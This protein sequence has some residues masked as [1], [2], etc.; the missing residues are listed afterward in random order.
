MIKSSTI[1][2]L[3]VWCFKALTERTKKKIVLTISIA[4]AIKLR[5][6][7]SLYE[8]QPASRTFANVPNQPTTSGKDRLQ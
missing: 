1:G 8:S 7:V 2:T 3:I 6:F 5:P 4:S